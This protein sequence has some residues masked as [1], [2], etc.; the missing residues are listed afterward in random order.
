MSGRTAGPDV[1]RLWQEFHDLVNVTSAQLQAWLMTEAASGD[2]ALSDE[3]RA[4]GDE[5]GRRIL[6]VLAKRK[7]DLT[8]ADLDAM[9]DV[10]GRIRGLLARRPAGGASD[11]AWRHAL[12]DL[13]HDPLMP[14]R[15]A[16]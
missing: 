10:V 9:Q 15:G 2:G 4:V 12:L 16:E 1:D 11:D 13:G 7:S 8:G 6:A 3:S 5:P 14:P